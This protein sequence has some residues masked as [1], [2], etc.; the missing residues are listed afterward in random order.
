MRRRMNRK[1]LGHLLSSKESATA[2]AGKPGHRSPQCHEKNH[3]R[4]EWAIHKAK[5]SHLQAP[6]STSTA[7]G[8]SNN[9]N[10]AKWI[11]YPRSNNHNQMDQSTHSV[12][13]SHYH[14]QLDF[15]GQSVHCDDLLQS[16]DGVEY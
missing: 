6:E 8:G 10:E 2:M 11:D 15:I 3:P 16:Q 14:V 5:Q 9:T 13:S 12:L 7:T 1:L 4:E